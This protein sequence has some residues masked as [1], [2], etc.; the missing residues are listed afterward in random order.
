MGLRFIRGRGR[1]RGANE[2]ET[3]FNTYFPRAF[4]YVYTNLGD[5]AAAREVVG[6]GFSQALMM[7]GSADEETF[8]RV[9]FSTLRELCRER[10]RKM[11]LDIVLAAAERDVITLTFDAG[12]PTSEVEV[13]VGEDAALNLSR[14]L[15]KM[16]ELASPSIIPSFFRLP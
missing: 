4:A 15:Q 8:R 11:P 12:L 7:G 2:D 14:G 13:I 6:A 9:L 1:G 10:R 16:R 5:E 3:R